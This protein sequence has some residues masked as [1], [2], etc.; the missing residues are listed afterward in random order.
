MAVSGS[1]AGPRTVAEIEAIAHPSRQ[2][3][4][5]SNSRLGMGGLQPSPPRDVSAGGAPRE[6][7]DASPAERVKIIEWVAAFAA[8]VFIAALIVA[9]LP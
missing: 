5:P 7:C 4:Y 6:D 9:V 1:S 3:R 2:S 8:V